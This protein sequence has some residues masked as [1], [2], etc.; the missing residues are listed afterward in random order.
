MKLARRW[1]DD[2]EPVMCLEHKDFQE[3]R[4][5]FAIEC[6]REAWREGCDRQFKEMGDSGT[7]VNGAGIEVYYIP[8][9]HRY[10]QRK[11]IVSSR[12]VCRAQG[13]LVW[14][15]EALNHALEVAKACGFDARYNSGWMD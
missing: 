7:C 3:V 10:A 13:S 2:P 5:S 6:V 15:G 9:R 4:W 12:E 14:E 8:P 11:M 1:R